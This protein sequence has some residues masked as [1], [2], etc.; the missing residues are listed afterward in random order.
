MYTVERERE[1]TAIVMMSFNVICH[2]NQ[3]KD[4]CLTVCNGDWSI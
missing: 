1:K 3:A 2:L 4:M